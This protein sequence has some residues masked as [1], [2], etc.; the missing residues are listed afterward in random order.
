MLDLIYSEKSND[1]LRESSITYDDKIYAYSE[2]SQMIEN[3][4]NCLKQIGIGKNDKVVILDSNPFEF[5]LVLLSL[6]RINSIPMPIYSYASQKKIDDIIDSFNI[7]YV[8]KPTKLDKIE[9][10]DGKKNGISLKLDS[11]VELD[12]YKFSDYVDDSLDDVSMIL[13][14]S[15]TTSTPKAIM[16]TEEN[17][18]SNV[19]AI[20]AYLELTKND[21]IL[22][23]KDLSH[24]SSI[25]GELF[26]GL[27]NGCCITMTSKLPVPKVILSLLEVNKISVFF[28]VPTLLKNIMVYPRLE[29]Y[30]LSALRTV[31]FYGASMRATD[32]EKLIELLPNTNIIYSYGQT[33]ASPRVTYI[34]KRDILLH[35][36][37][38]GKPIQD[39]SVEILS[40]GRTT[41]PYEI[42][43]IVVSGP[44][45]M[46]GYYMNEEKTKK[47]VQEG[48]L[49][50]GDYG[51]LD[52]EG[53]LY[54]KGRK[55][56][57]FTSAGKNI[58]PEEIEGVLT[59][60][61]EIKE[62]L[63]IPKEKDDVTAEI[64][65]YIVLIDRDRLNRQRLLEFCKKRLELYKIPKEVVVVDELEKTP[66]GKICRNKKML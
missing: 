30:N 19:K 60:Y 41:E 63:V 26:V 65:A 32:I 39:V 9:F 35:L 53:F 7:N 50:T 58:Y 34:E 33:E 24:S 48:K 17:I 23:I 54:V 2:L 21:N 43:E 55:D 37:S 29:E 18:I 10:S 27:Y 45:V 42:G 40:D 47:T 5:T 4:S 11:L 44:N 25:I 57:M 31:N 3:I 13:F 66:S 46:R 36:G 38:S 12:V 1:R 64:T 15:G 6:I 51:Y 28:A 22:I 61:D 20:S 16:L 52:E 49:F 14:T 59:T 62:A 56:N 8:V